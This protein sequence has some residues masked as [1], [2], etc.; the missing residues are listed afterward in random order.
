MATEMLARKQYFSTFPVLL[1][2]YQ[3]LQA[4]FPAAT[5]EYNDLVIMVTLCYVYLVLK[6]C[7]L[8]VQGLFYSYHTFKH[9]ANKQYHNPETSSY[10]ILITFIHLVK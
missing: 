3:V 6:K 8:E 2:I 4:D 9:A 5:I 10:I 1:Q 7:L